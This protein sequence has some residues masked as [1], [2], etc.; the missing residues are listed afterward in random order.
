MLKKKLT[1][2]FR[3]FLLSY[4]IILLFPLITG[5]V[6]Y[7]VSINVA[8]SSSIESSMLILKKSKEILENRMMEVE[9]FTRQLQ[10]VE[11]FNEHL[12]ATAESGPIDL[13]SLR[14][15]SRYISSYAHT[16]DFLTDSYIYL[17]NYNV[18]LSNGS[19]FFR[20]DH[21]YELYHYN[22]LSFDQWKKTILEG[23][24]QGKIIPV[25]SYTSNKKDL[26][27]I[28]YVQSLPIN[29]F[30]KPLGTSV[31]TIDHRKIGSLLEGLSKQYG[32]WAFIADNEGNPLTMVGIDESQT[33]KIVEKLK[34]QA[35]STNQYLE[36]GTMLISAESDFNGWQYVAG[37]PKQGLMEKAEIIK[38]MTWMVTGSTLLIGM[39][40][41]LFL[42]YRNST[43][44]HKLMDVVREHIGSDVSKH[45]NEYDFIHGNIS[46]LISNNKSLK[47]ELTS[48]KQIVK[49]S[50]I[51]SLLN[52]E[53]PTQQGIKDR[54]EQLEV[55]FQ[56]DVGYV[57]IL[58]INGY[59][60]ME[61]K[62]IH[63]ELGAARLIIKRTLTELEPTIVLT[64]LHSDKVIVIFSFNREKEK[65]A[66]N[67]I[68]RIIHT[69]SLS[70]E[71]AYRISISAVIGR[72][73]RNYLDI[74]RSYHEAKEALDYTFTLMDGSKMLWYKDMEKENSI[75]Y[76]P[77]DLELRLV[78]AIKTG[79]SHEVN[80]ILEQV[81]RE[82]FCERDLSP[83][84]AEQLLEEIKS[85]LIK[86]FDSN[87]YQ[88]SDQSKDLIKKVLQVQLKQEI[89]QV[90]KDFENLTEEFCNLVNKKKRETNDHAIKLIMKFLEDNY[91]DPDLSLY[92]ISE[93]IGL[94]EKFVSQLF[95]EQLGEFVSDYIEK[96]RI[97]KASELLVTT[98]QT[99]E[100]ISI[101]VGYN[102]AHSFR[103][104][105]KRVLHVTPKVYRQTISYN[106]GTINSKSKKQASS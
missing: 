42:A 103:R 88:G 23:N 63:D 3:K 105:F 50:F 34:K 15:T 28:T 80:Q 14:E 4:V 8:K 36:N 65:D 49:D 45:K 11:D 100:E 101:H 54:T 39:L 5:F 84:I 46:N 19:V 21:F 62:E 69:L 77:I 68:K 40:L 51:K 56:G 96:I 22:D 82:N 7:Q 32:G 92:R 30:N 10:S 66:A 18:I 72:S 2:T 79:E 91:S 1:K 24:H 55:Y 67:E 53:F 37:I 57:G 48:Q 59:G 73:F 35:G 87:M 90:W 60:H 31:I 12:S 41:C 16:N 38:H 83:K 95:K 75:F 64:D 81:F 25:R 104:A 44:I 70:M 71:R 106:D 17:K 98:D 97:N 85:T 61:N 26:S 29:S 78:N 76:Y 43:P 58:K 74:S 102:S 94:P 89:K 52:G 33:K 93:K 99:I 86:T 9:R 27:V 6:S 20:V 47:S 13:Y